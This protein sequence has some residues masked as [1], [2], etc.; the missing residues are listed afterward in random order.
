M[1]CFW[2]SGRGKV[3]EGLG[4]GPDKLNSLPIL[5]PS[6]IFVGPR[7]WN[8]LLRKYGICFLRIDRDCV[9]SNAMP[10]SFIDNAEDALILQATNG[11]TIVE[12]D[13]SQIRIEVCTDVQQ[14]IRP[15]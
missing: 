6:T 7:Q 14:R 13:S 9:Y 15:T 2:S 3:Q 4:R 8:G 11:A 12:N 1:Y 10:V 5:S